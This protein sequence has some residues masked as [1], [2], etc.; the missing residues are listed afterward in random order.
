MS[1]INRLIAAWWLGMAMGAGE[2]I[3]ILALAHKL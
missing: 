1:D 2:I 3:L